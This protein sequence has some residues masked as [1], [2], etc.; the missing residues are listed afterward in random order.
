VVLVTAVRAGH[1]AAG[2]VPLPGRESSEV[3]GLDRVAPPALSLVHSPVLLHELRPH[4]LLA[5]RALGVDVPVLLCL[6]VLVHSFALNTASRR[7]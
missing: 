6:V 7:Y 4:L 1:S 3:R 2:A 5:V